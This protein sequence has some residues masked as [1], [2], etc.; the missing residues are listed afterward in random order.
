MLGSLYIYIYIYYI[1]IYI[2]Y[3]FFIPDSGLLPPSHI[4]QT[5]SWDL[6]LA[7]SNAVSLTTSTLD[8]LDANANMA[9]EP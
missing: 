8:M 4:M 9:T 2:I 3:S 7:M 5:P 1:Y 6:G